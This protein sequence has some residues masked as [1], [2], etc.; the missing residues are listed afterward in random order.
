MATIS[1]CMIVKNE[2]KLLESA[3]ST[4]YKVADEIIITD[5]GSTD[6]TVEIAKKFTDKIYHFKWIDDFSAARNYTQEFAKMDYILRWDADWFLRDYEKANKFILNLKDN[7]FENADL[8]NFRWN[9]EFSK[10]GNPLRWHTNYFLYKRLKFHWESPIHNDLIANNQNLKI[11]SNTYQNVEVD[12]FKDPIDKAW[13][14]KQTKSILEKTL[15]KNPNNIR[16]K[17]FYIDALIFDKDYVTAEKQIQELLTYQLEFNDKVLLVEKLALSF[18]NL[19]RLN[20]AV[21]LCQTYKEELYSN[22][23]FKLIYADIISMVDKIQ[24]IMLYNN[25]LDAQVGED[26]KFL[27]FS[28]DRFIIHPNLMLGKLY[29]QSKK[30]RKAKKHFK[31]VLDNTN[32]TKIVK[33]ILPLFYLSVFLQFFG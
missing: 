14:Y 23:R 15:K 3:L 24:S 11:V 19:G 18:V 6:R 13:R 30:Y 21:K 16:L 12:H 28:I 27:D 26:F 29:F 1:L 5:T 10:N 8:I 7:N 32:D 33:Q 17:R 9:L 4:I 22:L 31:H 20:E 25:F 2:E